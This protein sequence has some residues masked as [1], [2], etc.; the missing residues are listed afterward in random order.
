MASLGNGERRYRVHLSG[1][2]AKKLRQIQRDATLERR[3]NQALHALRRIVRRPER[4]P[5]GFGEPVYR[6]PA[7]R[8]QVRRGAV[9][10]PLVDFAVS[11]DWLLV[12]VKGVKLLAD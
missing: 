6:L 10:P 4:D 3:G 9:R 11:E 2:I 7:L 8:L 1:L 5:S 12:F